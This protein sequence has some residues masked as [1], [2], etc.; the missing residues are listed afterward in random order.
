M[1]N[2]LLLCRSITHAQRMSAALELVG[3]RGKITRPPVGWNH[4]GCGY[5]IR[6]GEPFYDRAIRE[7][8]ALRLTPERVFLVSDDGAYREVYLR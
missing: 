3:V 8:T 2:Y 5:A 4:Q 1:N 6:I 7:L